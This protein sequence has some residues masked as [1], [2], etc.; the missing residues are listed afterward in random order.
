MHVFGSENRFGI[1]LVNALAQ[2]AE[3]MHSH[4]STARSKNPT[5][6]NAAMHASK[7]RRGKPP[8]SCCPSPSISVIPFATSCLPCTLRS[9]PLSMAHNGKARLGSLY[10]P[11][12]LSCRSESYILSSRSVSVFPFPSPSFK[13]PGASY[14]FRNCYKRNLTGTVSGLERASILVV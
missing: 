3:R 12:C 11:F 13:L 2:C 9:S 14:F 4:H 5:I 6:S 7:C 1:T 10:T 8:A